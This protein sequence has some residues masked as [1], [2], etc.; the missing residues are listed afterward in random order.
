MRARGDAAFLIGGLYLNKGLQLQWSRKLSRICRKQG[1][2]RNGLRNRR[3]VPFYRVTVK[4]LSTSRRNAASEQLFSLPTT[5]K[6]DTVK[7]TLIEN[8]PASCGI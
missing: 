6:W 2:P 4:H 1:E 3:V 5:K 8:L 7:H